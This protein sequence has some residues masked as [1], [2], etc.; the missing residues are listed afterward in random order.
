MAAGRE[1][2]AE[3]VAAG[4]G[5]AQEIPLQAAVGEVLEEDERQLH[6]ACLYSAT[7]ALAASMRA[8]GWM[9]F[10]R[11]E[12]AAIVRHSHLAR[13]VRRSICR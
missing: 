11:P 10:L 8:G 5:D 1:E 13:G 3:R 6:G 2:L 7:P 12:R 9:R 4:E